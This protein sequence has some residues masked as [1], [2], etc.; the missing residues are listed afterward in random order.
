MDGTKF[1]EE[2]PVATEEVTEAVVGAE[3]E[4]S[5]ELPNDFVAAEEKTYTLKDGTQG[6]RA[7]FIRE[8]FQ[9]DNLSRKE[10]ADKYG[11]AYR[12]VYSATVN[13]VNSAE[14]TTRGR[15][16]TNAVIKVTADTSAYVEVKEDGT[17]LANG[18]VVADPTLLGE[19][20]D[21][22]RNE[23]IVEQVRAGVE[24]GTLAKILDLSYGVIYAAT[25]EEE[26]SRTKVMIELEDGT[27]VTR[28]EYI[29]TQIAAG[30]ARGVLAKELDV[31]YSVIWQATKVE[32]SAQDKYN[33]HILAIKGF[34]D[35]IDEAQVANF[36][37]YVDALAL[38]EIKDAEAEAEAA[39]EEAAEAATVDT[40]A[41]Q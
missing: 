2:F 12:L 7:A 15:S 23:W 13:L 30:K 25:K 36:T 22:N 27:S 11:I 41:V 8:I 39:A 19:L 37:A 16:A 29:R 28:S 21:K 24:R 9:V 3:A 4:V 5:T 31:P 6:S 35:K 32:K 33:E 38:I 18:E 20:V 14:A 40:A 26:G 34:A 17:V 10:I 1:T